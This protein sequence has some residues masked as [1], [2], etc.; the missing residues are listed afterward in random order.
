MS[1]VGTLMPC[2]EVGEQHVE[3]GVGPLLPVCVLR[4]LNSSTFTH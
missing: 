1:I 4:G 2:V 3:A